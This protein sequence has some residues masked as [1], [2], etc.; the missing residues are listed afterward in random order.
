MQAEGCKPNLVTYNTLIDVYGKTGAWEDAVAVLD[1][2]EGQGIAPEVRTYNT[3][4][5]ACNQSS[6]AAQALHVYER[7]LAA[8]A[9]PTAT[10]YTALI[11]A[12]G[13]AGQ[14]DAA[15]QIFQDMV[16]RGCERNVITYSSLISACEKAGCWELA[17]KLFGEMHVEGCRPNVVTFNS[18]IAACAQ[19]AQWERAQ[20]LFEQMQG[21]GCRPDSVTFG[22]LIA[23]FDH[24]GLWQ[25]ALT[26]F[27]QMRNMNCRPDTVVYN[28]VIGALWKT[29]LVWAR[30]R[31]TQIFHGACRQGHF[32][33]TVHTHQPGGPSTESSLGGGGGSSLGSPTSS[34]T[35]DAAALFRMGSGLA[36]E[37]FGDLTGGS[38]HSDNL[39]TNTNTGGRAMS[40]T[41]CCSQ[42]KSPVALTPIGNSSAPASPMQLPAGAGERE[43]TIEFGMHAFTVGSAALSLLRWISELRDRLPWDSSRVDPRQSVALVL[44]KG[45]PSREHTYP[46][47]RD[48][49]TSMLLGWQAPLELADVTQGCRIEGATA[50]VVDWLKSP[51]VDRALALFSS[52]S[53]SPSRGTMQ[54]DSFFHEDSMVEG[55]CT[56]AFAAVRR[57]EMGCTTTPLAPT[58]AAAT[59]PARLKEYYSTAQMILGTLG[60]SDEV[61]YDGLLLV[62]R[63]MHTG[64]A[65]GKELSASPTAIVAACLNVAAR[66][67]KA[68]KLSTGYM[69]FWG[70]RIEAYFCDA[71]QTQL[72]T[73][74]F[75]IF[76]FPDIFSLFLS[77]SQLA[78]CLLPEAWM[79]PVCS[80]VKP[81]SLLPKFAPY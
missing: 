10:T 37:L 49:L 26:A 33:M 61:L 64:A 79:L 13:K 74:V 1:A 23:A 39:N 2:L 8:G 4:I 78:S 27:E 36:D 34:G 15:L 59:Q 60:Y 7:M 46:A 12:Y 63:V 70:I 62:D 43:A 66:Q 52:R 21:K 28:T 53:E 38:Q 16:A 20:A 25:R 73:V 9:K 67:G 77:L 57:F 55:R 14:L 32:R 30:T 80:L 50:D 48:A 51:L 81:R 44:N 11:S 47:I 35:I 71:G 69:S 41:S 68:V 58:T 19:G 31:A 54:R 42:Q 40:A 5:I 3:V 65:E 76:L 29:G 22:G 6:Q 56:E 45:K 18:L 17:L 72:L 75:T 24:A